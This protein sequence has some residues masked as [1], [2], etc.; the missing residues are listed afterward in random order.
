MAQERS[1]LLR[2]IVPVLL[3]ALGVVIALAVFTN[4]GRQQGHSPRGTAATPTAVTP[5]T[6]AAASTTPAPT[7]PSTA[8]NPAQPEAP[9]T[10]PASTTDA[11]TPAAPALAGLRAVAWP[12]SDAGLPYAPLGSLGRES[13]GNPQRFELRFSPNGAGLESLKLANHFAGLDV[14][15]PHEILQQ[16]ER[17]EIPM[18]DGTV[19]ERTLVP[20]ALLGVSIDG[21]FVN[22]AVSPDGPLWRQVAPGEF[23]A[24]IVDQDGRDVALVTRRYALR[25]GG[26]DLVLDQQLRNL[27]GRAISVTWHQFGP[28]DLPIGVI[29]Y[30]GDIRRIRLGYLT[31]L[32]NDP[33]QQMVF[34]GD[35]FMIPHATALGSP[36]FAPEGW[37][38]PEF[39]VWPEERAVRDGLSLA[40]AALTNRYFAVAV[41]P[42]PDRQPGRTDTLTPSALDKRFN[43]A[44][45]IDRVVLDRGG[46]D[47][48]DM[49]RRAVMA[50]RLTSPASMV[51][52]GAVADASMGI[53]AGPIARSF[54]EGEP[55]LKSMNLGELVI[56]SF[57]GPCAFCT[58]QPIAHLLRWYLGVLASYV[59]FDWAIAI[60]L[61]VVT[62]RTLLHPLTRWSQK[63]MTRFGKQ[64][65]AVAPKMQKLKEMYGND[66]AKFREEQ[67]KLMREEN[68]NYAGALGCLPM[69]FQMPI[70]IAL[71]AMIFFTFELR[72]EGAFFGLFQW[73][74]AGRWGFM[75]DLAEP[76]HFINLGLN[77]HIPIISGLMGPID[78]LNL[79]PILMGVVFYIQQK[80][81]TP[82]TTTQLSP[83]QEMQMKI[84]KFMIVVLFPLMMYNAPAALSLY[85]MTN[86]IGGI[87]ESKW[88]RAQVEREDAERERLRAEGKW[89]PKKAAP[90]KPGFFARI[91]NAV[92]E[93]Q[94]Q[95]EQAQKQAAKR[96][97]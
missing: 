65:A 73:L 61:L 34:G 55:L 83:E 81:L 36:T 29:R 87:I 78:G 39:A 84:T 67:V 51:A 59:V 48:N 63:S 60:I 20:F 13:E 15:A 11:P 27:T 50:L 45:R 2:I 64:M 22:L 75:A 12:E 82:P 4:T 7:S 79:L 92:E 41:H 49:L 9:A 96:K 35:R 71:Y 24:R 42:I 5:T 16:T 47:K 54:A 88:I 33:D 31:S 44:Q 58:F 18:T 37:V 46:A 6:P 43:L 56:F 69:F 80:Y 38:F 1:T 66:P 52:P 26:Y 72:H 40:W 53:Y 28:V 91:Q 70:W 94:R 57:G 32:A 77:L 8:P 89:P 74:S 76:D 62:L 23:T 93:K 19:R 86:S 25:A 90:A 10:T 17:H 95:F 68:V 21:T 97:K 14:N 3:A 85:F 30:G